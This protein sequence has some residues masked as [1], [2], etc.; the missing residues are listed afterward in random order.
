MVMKAA[1]P[2]SGTIAA[3]EFKAKCLGLLDDVRDGKKRLTITKHGKPYADVVPH[4][5]E[6][7][8]FRSVFGRTPNVVEHGDIM[9][10]VWE[11]AEDE[12]D[13]LWT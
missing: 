9:A 4:V 7:K 12:D 5:P 2:K 13:S 1:K 6:A 3:G 8:P 10:P 11:S